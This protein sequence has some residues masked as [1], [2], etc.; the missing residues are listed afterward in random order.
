MIPEFLYK[1]KCWWCGE[2]AN[3]KEHKFKS[4]DFKKT[5]GKN[6]KEFN[7]ASVLVKDEKQF[8]V[9]GPN[10]VYLKFHKKNLCENCNTKK[11]RD[12]D[13][14]YDE[15]IN[16]ILNNN[17]KI[18]TSQNLDF[19]KIFQFKGFEQKTNFI[20]YIVKHASCRIANHGL[21]I[22]SD[23][24]NFLNC[25][26]N[27]LNHFYIQLFHLM[28]IEA[29]QMNSGIGPFLGQASFYKYVL[30]NHETKYIYSGLTI[31]QFHIKYLYDTELTNEKYP[32]LWEYHQYPKM[33]KIFLAKILP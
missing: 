25:R 7:L 13:F 17:T 3:T 20:R 11:S 22:S 29:L 18:L 32:G 23:V 33:S 5:F 15:V 10:S 14:A 12:M 28:E 31:N 9:Q 6:P 1:H 26:T 19:T 21:K 30:E 24:I 2:I 4:S 8:N 27:K 16:Y